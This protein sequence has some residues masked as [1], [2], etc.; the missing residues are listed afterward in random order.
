M[1]TLLRRVDRLVRAEGMAPSRA[2]VT[3]LKLYRKGRRRVL[4]QANAKRERGE[5]GKEGQS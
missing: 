3:A 1:V 4:A 2:S 5:A